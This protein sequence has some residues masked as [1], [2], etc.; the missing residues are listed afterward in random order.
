MIDCLRWR[1][2]L[3]RRPVTV[4]FAS[5]GPRP[6]SAAKSATGD[7]AGGEHSRHLWREANSIRAATEVACV[8][9]IY[10]ADLRRIT[11]ELPPGRAEVLFQR[12]PQ[13]L[14]RAYPAHFHLLSAF[15][16]L[17]VEEKD[18]PSDQPQSKSQN[19]EE[20]NTPAGG[21]EAE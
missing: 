8:Y 13:C 1:T 18:A 3:V 11:G 9:C 20:G 2:E 16:P 7:L 19:K 21:A 17:Q 12:R 15:A 14:R 4:I 5:G 6:T 10:T